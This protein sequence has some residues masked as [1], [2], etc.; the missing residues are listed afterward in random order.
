M[1]EYPTNYYLWAVITAM[2]FGTAGLALLIERVHRG[3]LRGLENDLILAGLGSAALGWV[4]QAVGV[5][6]GVAKGF[7]WATL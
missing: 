6:C 5:V 1:R 4:V 3:S 7:S 2:I